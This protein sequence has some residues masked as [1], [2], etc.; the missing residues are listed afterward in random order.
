MSV[1]GRF[2]KAFGFSDDENDDFYRE[3]E[4]AQV[5]STQSMTK[6]ECEVATS[7]VNV[8]EITPQIFDGVIKI[9]NEAL[10]DFLKSCLDVEAQRRYIYNSLD[11]GLKTAIDKTM[12][13]AKST[14]GVQWK[15]ER[16]NLHREI[17]QLKTQNKSIGD[18]HTEIQ[19][20]FLSSER[21]K[22]ALKERIADLENQ[23]SNFEAEKEQ[24]ELEVKSLLN[25]LKVSQ[26]L[27]GDT[28][29]LKQEIVDLQEQLA[30]ARSNDK[31]SELQKLV[32]AANEQ[33]SQK[34]QQILALNEQITQLQNQQSE[35]LKV[36]NKAEIDALNQQVAEL[37]EQ[38][39]KLEEA[40]S[41]LQKKEEIAD[42]MVNDLNKKTAEA[43]EKLKQAQAEIVEKDEKI[44]LLSTDNNSSIEEVESLKNMLKLSNEELEAAREELSAN[45]DEIENAREAIEAIEEIQSQL[46]KFEE[47]KSKK[48]AQIAKLKNESSA[49]TAQISELQQKNESLE[50][51]I[52]KNL[53]AQVESE[54]V[55][56]EEI[57][58]LKSQLN[59]KTEVVEVDL[60]ND[61]TVREIEASVRRTPKISAID[62]SLDD[63]DWLVA[64]PPPG[65]VTRP[66]PAT[67]DD[68]FGYKSPV[69]KQTPENSAQMSLFE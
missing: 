55:L 43:I 51:T 57:E 40:L 60:D 45:K 17:E 38:N 63:T 50:K 58:K 42:A 23:V 25:K 4:E 24:Y 20:Q 67:T 52:E 37:T 27:D 66:T 2:K 62:D 19:Q 29:D 32:D 8:S 5:Y 15:S 35:N 53:Y 61:V 6:V 21:Q 10:P 41:Q 46:E 9:I 56:R 14:A 12:V 65:T 68:D 49:L 69:I 54:R 48:D 18:K 22:R 36:D 34:E 13:E 39:N 64:T 28:A 59:S 33:I 26:V 16:E 47:I 30:E 44:A 7:Q 11:E 3:N 1:L 31:G